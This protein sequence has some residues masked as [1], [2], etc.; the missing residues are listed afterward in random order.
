MARME[1]LRVLEWIRHRDGIWNLPPEQKAWLAAEFPSVRFDCPATRAEVDPLLPGADVVLGF[2]VQRENFALAKRLRWIHV[3]SAGVEGVL[4]PE[5]VESGIVLTSSRG[6]HARSIAEHTLGVMLAFVRQLHRS[7]DAQGRGDWSQLEQAE[8]RPGFE[9]L[10]GATVGIVG[11]GHIGSAIGGLCRGLGMRVLAVR[12]HPAADPAPA[13]AQWGLDRLPELLECSDWVVLAAPHTPETRG[14]IGA[15]ELARMRR[16]AR[17]INIGRGALVDEPALIDALA[18]GR[19]AGAGLDVFEREPLAAASPLW[20]MPQVIATP[21]VSGLG[22]RYWERATQVF[23]RN[24]RAFVSGTA[25]ENVV[26]KR[27]GY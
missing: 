11:F 19:L 3:T 20:S 5:L 25:L 17:L 26:D 16:G 2:A 22:P 9:E 27:A 12:R 13:H 10:H 23:A 24:L 15:A 14:I 4:F 7:R 6:L 8:A 1:T 18:S 21:H